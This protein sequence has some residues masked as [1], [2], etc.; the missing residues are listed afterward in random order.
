MYVDF[1]NAHSIKLT[2][3]FDWTNQ[4]I[5]E[6]KTQYVAVHQS[7]IHDEFEAL[8]SSEQYEGTFCSD[9]ECTDQDM[10]YSCWMYFPDCTMAY[11]LLMHIPSGVNVLLEIYEQYITNL[12]KKL[13]A[14][15]GNTVAK[16]S[17]IYT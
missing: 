5:Q 7:R 17:H 1:V 15:L 14:G 13:I 8:V 4:I 9:L 16:V 3:L 10:C 12:G 2:V 11:V 6:C